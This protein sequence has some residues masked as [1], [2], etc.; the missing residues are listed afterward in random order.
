MKKPLALFLALLFCLAT[1]LSSCDKTPE[2]TGRTDD[3]TAQ[4]LEVIA[5][6]GASAFTVVFTAFIYAAFVVGFSVQFNR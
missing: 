2:E 3:P 5:A 6:G 1:I 4:Y